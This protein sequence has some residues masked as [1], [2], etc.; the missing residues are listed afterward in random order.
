[1]VVIVSEVFEDWFLKSPH[2]DEIGGHSNSVLFAVVRKSGDIFDER[3]VQFIVD[4]AF[5]YS[6]FDVVDSRQIKLIFLFFRSSVLV[7]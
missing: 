1:M 5:F 4:D 6:D 7:F 2:F 3:V